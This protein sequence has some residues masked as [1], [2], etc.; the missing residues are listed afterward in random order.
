MSKTVVQSV[1]ALIS[2]GSLI[3]L[4]NGYRYKLPHD[5][6]A[7][8]RRLICALMVVMLVGLDSNAR[9]I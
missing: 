4:V 2:D 6:T 1:D 7:V 9:F 8:S 3:R 5:D